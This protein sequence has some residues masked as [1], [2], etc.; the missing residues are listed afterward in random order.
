[1]KAIIRILPDADDLTIHTIED[2]RNVYFYSSYVEV[3]SKDKC[4]D[5]VLTIPKDNFV[6]ITIEK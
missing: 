4:C 2:F 1:M 6:S 3:R 5:K